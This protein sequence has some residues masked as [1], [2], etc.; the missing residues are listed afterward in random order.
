MVRVLTGY[1]VKPGSDILPLLLQLRSSE[2][3]Y[4]GFVSAENLLREG[5]KTIVVKMTT[6]QTIAHWRAWETSKLR[7][8]LMGQAHELLLGE[9]VVTTYTVMPTVGWS[10][11]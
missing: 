8:A 5:D 3:T 7:Q 11:R 6:W 2:A 1:K 4:P 10:I 9:P